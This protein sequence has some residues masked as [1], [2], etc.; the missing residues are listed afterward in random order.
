MTIYKLYWKIVKKNRIGILVYYLVFMTMS[1]LTS[2]SLSNNSDL[3]FQTVDTN[4]SIQNKDSNSELIKG[5]TQYLDSKVS[6]VDAPETEDELKDSLFFRAIE[7][8]ITI[9]QGFSDS[10]ISKN[11]LTLDRTS[12][13]SSYSS[14][15]VDS[16]IDSY[17]NTYRTLSENQPGTSPAKIVDQVIQ[18]LDVDT[19]VTLYS[20][21]TGNAYQKL[22]ALF[23][24][25]MYSAISCLILSIAAINFSF[26]EKEVYNRN[27]IAPLST[28]TLALKLMLSNCGLTVVVWLLHVL[29]GFALYRQQLWSMRGVFLII[30]LLCMNIVA[31]SIS[32][33][34]FRL[35]KTR[36]SVHFA[37]NTIALGMSFLCGAFVPQSMLGD[38][39]LRVAQFLPGYWYI[40]ANNIICTVQEFTNKEINKILFHYLVLL[41][42][43]AAL[44]S[45]S[46]ILSKQNGKEE[47]Q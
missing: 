18:N 4:V 14:M 9:P 32:S 24:L 12:I 43:A 40:R 21:N 20:K 29:V 23:N 11:P 25:S 45:L 22:S 34:V 13:N 27:I 46:L 19:N 2:M 47:S 38:K 39:V 33:L 26:Y 1:V 8:S 15:Y 17:L 6:L 7:Y 28:K 10:L 30:N 41:A 36:S 16:L 5:L 37:A 35:L 31:L 44:Y 3:N 42:F